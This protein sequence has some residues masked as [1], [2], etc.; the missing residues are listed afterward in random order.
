MWQVYLLECADGTLYCGVTTDLLRRLAE[1][2][3]EAPGGARYTSSRRPVR[4][5]ASLEVAGRSEALALEWR[6]KKLKRPQKLAVFTALAAPSGRVDEE[7][8]VPVRPGGRSGG[9][10]CP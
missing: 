8:A 1:H 2:N 3:G 6:I 4:L 7:G 10:A 9:G 5:A